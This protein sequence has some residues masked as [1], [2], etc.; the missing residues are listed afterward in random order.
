[1]GRWMDIELKITGNVKPLYFIVEQDLKRIKRSLPNEIHRLPVRDTSEQTK[2]FKIITSGLEKHVNTSLMTFIHL[3]FQAKKEIQIMTP[4]LIMND[5][6]I[7]ALL[8]QANQG[9]KISILMPSKNDHPF[10]N[11]ASRAMA[12]KL[13]HPNIYIHLYSPQG[14]MHAKVLLIDDEQL[15]VTSAN[16][17]NRS[18]YYNLELGAITRDQSLIQWMAEEFM[19]Q[20][21][22]SK[23]FTKEDVRFIDKIALLFAS[24]L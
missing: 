9:C 21:K 17:D 7:D 24:F 2:T 20:K 16:I 18:F 19:I 14:F 1:M 5:G 10:V 12:K 8:Y 6:F 4:Y 22:Q 15:F 3:I 13:L 11:N 23:L